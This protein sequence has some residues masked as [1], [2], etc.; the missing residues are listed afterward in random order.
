[1]RVAIDVDVVRFPIT[2]VGRYVYELARKLTFVDGVELDLFA[3]PRRIAALPRGDIVGHASHSGRCGLGLLD[4]LSRRSWPVGVHRAAVNALQGKALRDRRPDVFHGPRF[5]L[6]R[7]DGPRVVTI[8]DLSMFGWS[9]CHPSGR[10]ASVRRAVEQAVQEE[11][12]HIITVSDYTRRELCGRYGLAES[13]VSAVSLACGEEFQALNAEDT[14]EML[15]RHGLRHDGYSLF[16]GTVEPRKNL[17]ALLVA[18]EGLPAAL[19]SRWPLV[20]CGYNGWSSDDIH[21]RIG[22]ARREGWVQYLGYVSAGE[23][24]AIYA[25]ARLFAFP[26][27]YEGF[28]LPVLEAMTSGVPVVCSNSSSLPEVAGDSALMIEPVDVDGLRSALERGLTDAQWRASAR[29]KG[30]VR[31]A[32][33]SW[34]RCAAETVAVYRHVTGEIARRDH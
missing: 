21:E 28:G 17:H 27:F 15:R 1:M 20:L 19:R 34:G 2:G 32:G 8:H 12:V 14:G 25:G 9:H 31:A 23:L 3:G 5:F 18:Y 29:S 13:R 26:S 30:L 6:P 16:V 24:P 22:R 7:F 11:S 4:W 33:F 10:L